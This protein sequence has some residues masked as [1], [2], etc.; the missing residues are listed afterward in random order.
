MYQKSLVNLFKSIL[1][2]HLGPS[3]TREEFIP[4]LIDIIEDQENEDEFLILLCD[5]IIKLKNSIGGRNHLNKLLG[6]L[7]IIGCMEETTVR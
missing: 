5:E 3:R 6:P 1:I 7:E 4:Y 2:F